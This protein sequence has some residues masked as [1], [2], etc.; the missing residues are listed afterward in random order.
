MHWLPLWRRVEWPQGGGVGTR[1]LVGVYTLRTIS[2]PRAPRGGRPLPH[3]RAS[4]RPH[5][6]TRR[7]RGSHSSPNA[8]T[9]TFILPPHRRFWVGGL[10]FL[11]M[12]PERDAAPG[13]HRIGGTSGAVGSTITAGAVFVIRRLRNWRRSAGAAPALGRT[14]RNPFAY[15]YVYAYVFATSLGNVAVSQRTYGRQER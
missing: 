3:P 11:H 12:S 9:T 2:S 1:T 4:Q 14:P 13:P 6:R 10:E 7:M 8:I 5:S 15:T